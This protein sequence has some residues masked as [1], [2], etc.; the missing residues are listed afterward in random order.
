MP[1]LATRTQR[2]VAVVEDDPSLLNALQRLLRAASIEVEVFTSAERFLARTAREELSCLIV[3]INLPGISGIELCRRLA[4]AGSKVP[5]I[6]ITA[7]R[8]QKTERDAINAG[9]AA[10]LRKPIPGGV[11]IDTI[12]RATA[13]PALAK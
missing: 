7:L 8:D 10:Y 9:A 11:L 5:A 12:A 6:F 3:D 13:V 2:R 1:G 4:A